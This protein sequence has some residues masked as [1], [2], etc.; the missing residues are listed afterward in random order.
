MLF[1]VGHQTQHQLQNGSSLSPYSSLKWLIRMRYV[2][3]L[4]T[5]GLNLC[6]RHSCDLTTCHMHSDSTCYVRPSNA[7]SKVVIAAQHLKITV[8]LAVAGAAIPC[9]VEKRR[10]RSRWSVK[11]DLLLFET[12]VVA[13][14]LYYHWPA[15]LPALFD[16][17]MP[18]SGYQTTTVVARTWIIYDQHRI[19]AHHPIW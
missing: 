6:S 18:P 8:I 14:P 12:P 1:L 5:L 17:Q 3:T 4:H 7:R 2:C 9:R 13:P 19:N 11:R 10:G 16:L 15:C